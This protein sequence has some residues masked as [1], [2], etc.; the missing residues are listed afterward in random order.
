MDLKIILSDISVVWGVLRVTGSTRKN[1]RGAPI[2]NR[3][4]S[5]SLR[6]CNFLIAFLFLLFY[7]ILFIY[8]LF[9]VYYCICYIL[10]SLHFLCSKIKKL[11]NTSCLFSQEYYSQ[12]LRDSVR[13]PVFTVGNLVENLLVCGVL[14]SSHHS[15]PQTIRAK[16]FNLWVFFLSSCVWSLTFWR[17]YNI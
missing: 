9:S 17:S 8:V 15:T 13:F 6:K 5:T 4:Y 11:K 7:F 2:A 10:V 16:Q 3:K 14:S 12:V 1:A